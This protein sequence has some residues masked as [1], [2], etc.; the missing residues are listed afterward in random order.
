MTE[1]QNSKRLAFDLTCNLSF[2]VY[3]DQRDDP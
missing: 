1:I 2:Q 3:P